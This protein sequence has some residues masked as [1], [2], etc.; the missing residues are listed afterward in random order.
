MGRTRVLG[1]RTRVL[2]E[3]RETMATFVST[4]PHQDLTNFSTIEANSS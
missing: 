4:Y 3:K 1:E 2:G